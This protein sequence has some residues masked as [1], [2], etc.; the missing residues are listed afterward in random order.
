M[1]ELSLTMSGVCALCMRVCCLERAMGAGA[2]RPASTRWLGLVRAMREEGLARVCR[3]GRGSLMWW[4]AQRKAVGHERASRGH[5]ESAGR[6]SETHSGYKSHHH[7]CVMLAESRWNKRATY[8]RGRSPGRSSLK[9]LFIFF[10]GLPA[11]VSAR[12]RGKRRS[13]DPEGQQI[14]IRAGSAI[15]CARAH[16]G[17]VGPKPSEPWV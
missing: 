14:G 17:G 10:L 6:G 7:P 12:V 2:S 1:L 15:S 5:G 13:S 9:L 3:R 4:R 16:L 11:R 8:G